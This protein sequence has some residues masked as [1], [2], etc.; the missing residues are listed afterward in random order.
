M[1]KFDGRDNASFGEYQDKLRVIFYLHHNA[2][3][4]ILQGRQRPSRTTIGNDPSNLD[5]PASL[6]WNRANNDP[7]SILLF[8]TENSAKNTVRRFMGKLRRTDLVMA[9]QRGQHCEKNMTAD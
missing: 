4:E 9:K 7:F 3:A 8:T 2:A 1:Y 5:A 6:S